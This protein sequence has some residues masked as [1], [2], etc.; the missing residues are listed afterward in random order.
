[1]LNTI[2]VTEKYNW[3]RR[4]A[5]VKLYKADKAKIIEDYVSGDKTIRQLADEWFI[6]QYRIK[7]VIELYYKKPD[8]TITIISKV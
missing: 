4:R 2:P 8:Y 3:Y 6:A 5:N 1:M 7:E